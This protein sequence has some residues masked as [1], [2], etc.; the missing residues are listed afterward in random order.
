MFLHPIFLFVKAERGDREARRIIMKKFFCLLGVALCFASC[1]TT[2]KTSKTMDAS[3]QLLSATV[4]DL[5][6]SPERISY[7]MSP[8]IAVRRAGKENVKQVAEQEA[9]AKH[10][11]ADVL[12]EANYSIEQTSF[13]VFKWISSITVTGRPAKY[14]NFH[15]LN[16]SVWCNPTFR[17]NYSN[18]TK[19]G[20]GVLGGLFK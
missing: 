13:L 8:T 17:R 20:G 2:T 19:Q 18:T 1:V 7:T 14:T 12:V 4:A 10:G 3:A 11:N 5:D 6:I 16:D 15:S 9:L